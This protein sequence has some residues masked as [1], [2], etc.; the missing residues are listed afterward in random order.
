[1]ST[2]HYVS[3][4]ILFTIAILFLNNYGPID[5][6]QRTS[7]N[8]CTIIWGLWSLMFRAYIKT[9]ADGYRESL[10][11]LKEKKYL[12]SAFVFGTTSILSVIYF[13]IWLAFSSVPALILFETGRSLFSN[14]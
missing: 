14:G 5:H 12:S 11:D 9:P 13:F 1:M 10:V 2:R 4:V 6:E 3:L 8:I 7:G